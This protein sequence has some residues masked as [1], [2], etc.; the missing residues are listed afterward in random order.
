VLDI[1]RWTMPGR[2]RSGDEI[3]LGSRFFGPGA[4]I[5]DLEMLS[6]Q[7]A[8]GDISTA[9]INL[10]RTADVETAI[11]VMAHLERHWSVER[12]ERRGQRDSTSSSVAVTAGFAE[13]VRRISGESHDAAADE[14]ALEIWG[15]DN[16][17]D[18]GFGALVPAER[19]EQ[20]GVGTVL[21]GSTSDGKALLPKAA[22]AAACASVA[23][24]SP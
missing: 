4:A 15:L 20:L 18:A 2:Y 24:S 12:P 9:D 5:A 17:S 21:E 23:D 11:D 1:D 8:A 14:E 16:E 7:L 10:D 13:I 6:A 3:R 22:C 19:G